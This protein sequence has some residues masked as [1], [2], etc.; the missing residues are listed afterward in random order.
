MSTPDLLSDSERLNLLWQLFDALLQHLHAALTSGGDPVKASML[1]VA[2]HFLAANNISASTRADMSRGLQSLAGFR[3]L[4][5][6]KDGNET[7]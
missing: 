3:G 4:P 2:R 5:F 7:A 6:D 1:D